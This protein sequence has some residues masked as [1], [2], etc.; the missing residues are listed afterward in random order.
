MIVRAPD[1]GLPAD[2]AMAAT[3]L[4]RRTG[5]RTTNERGRQL[6]RPSYV[7]GDSDTR[8]AI[9]YG[10]ESNWEHHRIEEGAWGQP[11]ERSAERPRGALKTPDR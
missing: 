10:R 8:V 1:L 11:R 5:E 2:P 9:I 4:Q 6:R 3:A 7:I